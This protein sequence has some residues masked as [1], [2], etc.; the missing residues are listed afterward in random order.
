MADP[1]AKLQISSTGRARRFGI[2]KLAVKWFGNDGATS[3]YGTVLGSYEKDPDAAVQTGTDN[4]NEVVTMN[5]TQ[6]KRNVKLSV[7]MEADTIAHA[8]DAAENL[9]MKMDIVSIGHTTDGTS[10]TY[11]TGGAGVVDAQV[12]TD[13]AI[14]E[15]AAPRYSP[16]GEL[17]IDFNLTVH[18][19]PDGTIKTFAAVT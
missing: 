4:N 5:R 3:Y 9:P 7:K 2:P 10:A 15:S 1:A 11:A 14:V 6:K 13:S 16:E 19:N 17:V 12:E 8:E 18:L